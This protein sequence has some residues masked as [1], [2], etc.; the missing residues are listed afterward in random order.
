MDN[1]IQLKDGTKVE[2]SQETAD[3]L[4]EQ[5][6]KEEIKYG[7]YGITECNTRFV[8]LSKD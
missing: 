5:F 3:N 1:I 8:W 4:K 2:I 7:D 6:G